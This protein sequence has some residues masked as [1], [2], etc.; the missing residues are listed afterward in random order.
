VSSKRN[1][2]PPYYLKN[3]STGHFAKSAGY[4]TSVIMVDPATGGKLQIFRN[5]GTNQ[6][7]IVYYLYQS[8]QADPATGKFLCLKEDPG[9][10]GRPEVM[11][12]CDT[13]GDTTSREEYIT[14]APFVVGG[15]DVAFTT[16][17]EITQSRCFNSAADISDYNQQM[18]S[19][20]EGSNDWLYVSTNP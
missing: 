8:A 20:C 5:F 15:S 2:G 19:R 7:G 13:S 14:D 10:S 6:N 1:G 9:I 18:S 17:Y 12:D 3:V 4:G 11:L 16:W